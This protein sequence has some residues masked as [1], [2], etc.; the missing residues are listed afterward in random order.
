MSAI[1]DPS[2]VNRSVL[3]I[4][5]DSKVIYRLYVERE[6]RKNFSFSE[7]KAL[8]ID[9]LKQIKA[10]ATNS[11]S[12]AGWSSKVAEAHVAILSKYIPKLIKLPPNDASVLE[13]ELNR[14]IESSSNEGGSIHDERMKLFYHLSAVIRELSL[15]KELN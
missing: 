10:S 15:F 1:K 13:F 9:D 6:H 5:R 11:L 2:L 12:S 14:D 7:A 4:S 3:S 8:I